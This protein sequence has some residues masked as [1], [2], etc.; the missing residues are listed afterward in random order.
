MTRGPRRS[1]ALDAQVLSVTHQRDHGIEL[2]RLSGVIGW[3]LSLA[4]AQIASFDVNR[5]RHDATTFGKVPAT[6][7]SANGMDRLL[8]W[9]R[10]PRLLRGNRRS[11]HGYNHISS[12]L[13]R[14][15]IWQGGLPP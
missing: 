3:R 15:R 4:D 10:G 7:M 1:R 2:V 14:H 5:G 8:P 12:R 9:R 13:D 6:W 11:S